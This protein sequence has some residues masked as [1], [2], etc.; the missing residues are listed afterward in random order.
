MLTT[1]NPIKLI[2]SFEET[3]FLFCKTRNL[4]EI[5]DLVHK[6]HVRYTVPTLNCQKQNQC[7]ELNII[8]FEM[9]RRNR[10]K[11]FWVN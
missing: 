3:S 7:H 2:N 10:S 9:I 5:F 11:N 8:V 6:S 1:N 4:P